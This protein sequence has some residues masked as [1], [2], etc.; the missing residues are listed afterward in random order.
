MGKIISALLLAV[1]ALVVLG[2]YLNWFEIDRSSE[3][4]ETTVS[5]KINREKIQDDAEEAAEKTKEFGQ[6]VA[7]KSQEAVQAAKDKFQELSARQTTH[8]TLK[9]IQAEQSKFTLS[10]DD[11]NLMPMQVTDKTII[12]RNGVR[13]TLDDLVVGQPV[14]VVY[15]MQET[16]RVAE[17]VRVATK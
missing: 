16:E 2:F 14:T 9:E 1:I 15:T 3:A 8:G 13:I 6:K 17:S 11:G 4:K 12:E 5:L 10:S 7:Q